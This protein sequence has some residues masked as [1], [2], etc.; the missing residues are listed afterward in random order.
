MTL[1]CHMILQLFRAFH[2]LT[3]PIALTPQATVMAIPATVKA[4]RDPE[5]QSFHS[6]EPPFRNNLPKQPKQPKQPD[7]PIMYSEMSYKNANYIL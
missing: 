5:H 3:Y 6:T 7:G 2:A 1:R 4:L